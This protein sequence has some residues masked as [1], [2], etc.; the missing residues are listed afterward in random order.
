MKKE[1]GFTLIELLIVVGIVSL[2]STVF[3][4]FTL[5]GSRYVNIGQEELLLGSQSHTISTVLSTRINTAKEIQAVS[6]SDN[7]QA[8]LQYIDQS[9]ILITVFYNSEDNQRNFLSEN[10][11]ETNS[12]VAV[13]GALGRD[14]IELIEQNVSGFN[15]R[16][17][18]EDG[19]SVQI[20]SQNNYVSPVLSEI[21]SLKL[22]YTLSVSGRVKPVTYMVS[23][24]KNELTDSGELIFG[25]SENLFN[26]LAEIALEN[27]VVVQADDL[28]DDGLKLQAEERTVQILN[29]GRFF[30]S[31][32]DAINA[33]E[34]GDT[35]LVAAKQGAYED[36]IQMKSGIQLLGGYNASNWTRD[37][38]NN[39]TVLSPLVG[40]SDT[41]FDIQNVSDVL[42]EG[43]HISGNSLDYGIY[44]ENAQHVK[45]KQV[46]VTDV[47]HAMVFLNSDGVI[48]NC[49]VTANNQAIIV[50]NSE[51]GIEIKR[52]RLHTKNRVQ[53]E[54]LSIINSE[55]VLIQNN[56]IESGYNSIRLDES[57][58][59]YLYNNVFHNAENV[60]IYIKNS[61]SVPIYNNVIAKNDVGIELDY[62]TAPANPNITIL[63]NAFINNATQP[64]LGDV[65]DPLDQNQVSQIGDLAWTS[66]NPYFYDIIHFFP[67]GNSLSSIVIDKGV[68]LLAFND[69]AQFDNASLA[70][71]PSSES[72][73]SDIGVYGGSEA[74]RVGVGLV[75]EINADL[76]N[77]DLL[78]IFENTLPGDYVIAESGEYVFDETIAVKPSVAVGGSGYLNT[79]F[80]NAHGD[81]VFQAFGNNTFERFEL[82][83]NNDFGIYVTGGTAC[84]VR[85][86][87]FR[88][89]SSAL[90]LNS[91]SGKF[92]FLTFDENT[93][94]ILVQGNSD[95]SLNYTIF[96]HSNLAI[97]HSGLGTV[98][99]KYNV[100]YGTDTKAV[101]A[102]SSSND[103]EKD[104]SDL[105]FWGR[106]DGLYKLYEQSNLI[107]LNDTVSPG[108]DE[109][110]VNEG[111][112]DIGGFGTE[113]YRQYQ[114]LD[115]ELGGKDDLDARFSQIVIAMVQN[116]MVVTVSSSIIVTENS[117]E[118][119]QVNLPVN[120]I[121]KDAVFRFTM[122]SFHLN[123]S[124]FVNS[125]KITW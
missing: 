124:P 52:T 7:N 108:A 18:K 87:V 95:V 125:V 68:N 84:S 27:S 67:N 92:E 89:C 15:I 99:G 65:L 24:Y 6:L 76:L 112:V 82:K 97:N 14:R 101:G 110:I 90:T 47:V 100:F 69:R 109:Y 78:Q 30:N 111:Y 49:E 34:Y 42:I 21:N 54:V 12:I 17:Y 73:R 32:S 2:L 105:V 44:V 38:Q 118:I 59:C 96:S 9:G 122:K 23:L 16:T 4:K 102:Y 113:D 35:I 51:S 31:I 72:L 115:L 37:W 8:F 29:S 11:F 121:A 93:T 88:N 20:A 63:N 1:N 66:N 57:N 75:H 77:F 64:L 120:S 103:V 56:I 13:F 116:E 10:T 3:V 61:V 45:L 117:T 22:S 119:V 81:Y 85:N 19:N 80:V 91:V 41:G 60:G 123:H 114:T 43:F 83:G 86:V 104:S 36:R 79:K 55:D 53:D 50:E 62:A 107:Q 39:R 98:E 5:L 106:Q 33:A 70:D 74:G 28:E 71:K 26:S 40:E 94:D 48:M 25:T 58:N 46:S